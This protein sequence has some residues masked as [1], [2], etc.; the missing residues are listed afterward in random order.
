MNAEVVFFFKFMSTIV[1]DCSKLYQLFYLCDSNKKYY[2]SA[3][4]STVMKAQQYFDFL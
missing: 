3:R 2:I 1:S 4:K